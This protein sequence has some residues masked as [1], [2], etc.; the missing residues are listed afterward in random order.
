MRAVIK[1]YFSNKYSN[2]EWQFIKFFFTAF[3]LHF[4]YQM[5][6]FIPTVYRKIGVCNWI[7]CTIIAL[8]AVKAILFLLLIILAILYFTEN[9]MLLTT[10]LLGIIFLFLIN[11][12]D[13]AGIDSR[14]NYFPFVFFAQSLA[15]LKYKITNKKPALKQDRIQYVLQVLVVIYITAVYSKLQNSNL[16]WINENELM[17]LNAKKSIMHH[18]VTVGQNFFVGYSDF[19]YS[20]FKANKW[21]VQFI[22]FSTLVIE[23]IVIFVLYN[24]KLSVIF[25]GLIFI[26]HFFILVLMLVFIPS[27]FACVTI[28]MVNLPYLIYLLLVVYLGKTLQ[29]ILR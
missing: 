2:T 12:L 1:Q 20:F 21:F 5:V 19:M 25:G 10:F 26:M 11:T 23:T 17:A 22:L 28:F 27:I 9:L 7:D 24:K 4:S 3:W 6:F 14:S 18:Y 8:P 29:V 16:D 13:S 15:Y